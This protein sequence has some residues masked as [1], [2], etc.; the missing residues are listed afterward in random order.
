MP[1]LNKQ[2]EIKTNISNIVITCVV[3]A[4]LNLKHLSLKWK[5]KGAQWNNV[6]FPN[7]VLTF[8]YPKCTALFFSSGKCVV[9]GCQT[10]PEGKY[11]LRKICFMLQD[12][13]YTF[14]HCTRMRIQNVVGDYAFGYRI[15][16]QALTKAYSAYCKTGKNFP[17]TAMK[18][19]DIVQNA[20]I[21]IFWTGSVVATA[22]KSPLQVSQI[23]IDIGKLTSKFKMKPGE[24]KNSILKAAGKEAFQNPDTKRNAKTTYKVFETLDEVF[25]YINSS[26]FKE[27]ST[28]LEHANFG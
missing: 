21:L 6:R 27:E 28:D 7:L 15:N 12:A 14:A 18:N 16:I 24:T 5:H 13:G 11:T 8:R 4:Y 26:K 22:G 19:L 20:T 23:M 1:R 25:N 9:E 3:S 17:S 2:D 10:I